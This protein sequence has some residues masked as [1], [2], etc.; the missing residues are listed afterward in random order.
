MAIKGVSD[1]E[2]DWATLLHEKG[3]AITAY[4]TYIE[5][6]KA[7]NAQACVELFEKLK[8]AD[9]EQMQEIRNHLMEVMQNSK[10]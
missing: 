3:K 6:A 5:D 8:Q 7:A 10:G 2:Y 1:L 9:S 4:D